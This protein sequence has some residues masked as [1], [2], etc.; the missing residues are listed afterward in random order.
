[1]AAAQ[2]N[3]AQWQ[4][5]RNIALNT[6]ASGASVSNPVT[7]FPV[8]IR[9]TAADSQV[10]RKS[11][12]H[13]QDVRFSKW[14]GTHLSYQIQRWDSTDM[15]AE[16]WVLVDT[17]KGSDSAE[18]AY[19]SGYLKMYWGNGSAADSENSIAVFDTG[20]GYQAVWHMAENST[21]NAVDATVNGFIG[22]ASATAPT[23]STDGV[24]GYCRYFN[25]TA[26]NFQVAGSASGK[27]N[28]IDSSTYSIS[29]WVES[30]TFPTT[31]S[32]TNRGTIVG[33]YAAAGGTYVAQTV[34]GAAPV[35]ELAL[36][37]RSAANNN[38]WYDMASTGDA[39]TWHYVT[40]T[41]Q[42]SGTICKYLDGAFVDSIVTG[43]NA[44]GVRDTTRTVS[45]GSQCTGST[46]M[47]YFQG[48]LDEV[49]LANVTRS[50]SW[51]QL[52]FKN[53]QAAQTLVVKGPI[54]Q[55]GPQ[56][57]VLA[58]PTNG[59]NS[60][61]LSPT[62]TWGS[63]ATA[64]AY[65]VQLS[66]ASNFS[67]TILDHTVSGTSQ[68]V[69]GLTNSTMYYW[70]ANASSTG[71][72]SGWS[73]VWSF[74]TI[75]PWAAPPLT[76]PTNGAGNQPVSPVL[77]WNGVTGAASYTLQ[78]STGTSFNTM[79]FNQS[80]LT[81]SSQ[82]VG[83]LAYVSTYFWRVNAYD[84]V[85]V[86][87]LWS[88]VWSF[89]TTMQVPAAP[90]LASPSSGTQNVLLNTNLSWGTVATASAYQVQVS[91]DVNFGSTVFGQSG[92]TLTTIPASGLANSTMYYWRAGAANA[93]GNGSWSG[94]WNFV[95]IVAAAG[96]PA[97]SSPAS[98]LSGLA[99]T[100]SLSWG[101]ASAASSY[102]LQVSTA[103]NFS[104]TVLSA[105]EP[106]V[107]ASVSNL[108]LG[109]TYYWQVAAVNAAGQGTWSGVWNFMTT[110]TAVLTKNG[111]TA[112]TTDFS[113]R[114]TA[115]AYSLATSGAIEISFSDLLGRTALVVHRTMA[116]GSYTM[117][118]RD[119]AIAS[120]RYIVQFKAA[121]IEKQAVVLIDR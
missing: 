104:T 6:Q 40:F 103:S 78:V 24:L 66:S 83:P 62:L 20:N 85:S 21:G 87:S 8:L 69:A 47:N 2:D 96:V 45:I 98:G 43:G 97:L 105:S 107:S 101:S 120:G 114:G 102:V 91:T 36:D 77:A 15:L 81:A 10:F 16:L 94:T 65:E 14:D 48:K 22:T 57:P 54:Q 84:G 17:V 115:L 100:L 60:V 30:D 74:T 4:Y 39:H 28:F 70:R 5:Y 51:I 92:L 90:V 67:S 11:L 113:V 121:G 38:V 58:S 71:G 13:G 3:Y 7:K 35:W 80:A 49:I 119:C 12:G 55:S 25:G 99:T 31:N 32:S 79:V 9:L 27:L 110:P 44:K 118:L 82:A 23:D 41:S 52:S 1:M 56:A 93:G 109:T 64:T 46:K 42:T 33:K 108:A 111:K 68:T 95:T 89:T 18:A 29:A 106:G 88:N 117:A 19:P 112:L 61:P 50:P 63:S 34:G 76:S 75:A 116:A 73:G 59:A 53:Q 72:S 26:A 86:T 37:T